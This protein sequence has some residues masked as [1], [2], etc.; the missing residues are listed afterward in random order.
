MASKGL[1]TKTYQNMKK[2]IE[3]NTPETPQQ[4]LL[5]IHGVSKRYWKCW[6]CG[7]VGYTEGE[8]VENNPSTM[9]CAPM[10][11]RTSGIC[12]G[13]FSIEITEQEYNERSCNAC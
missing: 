13:S 3:S 10:P 5:A 1:I 11:V 9:C 2:K 4:P 12:G 6:K 7:A 8:L